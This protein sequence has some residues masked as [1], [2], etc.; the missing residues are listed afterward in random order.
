MANFTTLVAPA[1][2]AISPALDLG[3]CGN[4]RISDLDL[5]PDPDP[6][7]DPPYPPLPLFPSENMPTFKWGNSSGTEFVSVYASF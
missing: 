1:A 2:L 3:N 4:S 7:P 5:D 6:D